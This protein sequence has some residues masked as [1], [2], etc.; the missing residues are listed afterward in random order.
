MPSVFVVA[1]YAGVSSGRI[2]GMVSVTRDVGGRRWSVPDMRMRTVC[3]GLQFSCT[4][5][6][7]LMRG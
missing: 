7:L 1:A 2:V 5:F 4:V 3:A 6:V